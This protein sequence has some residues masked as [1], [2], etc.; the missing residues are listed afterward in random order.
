VPER[1]EVLVTR[2]EIVQVLDGRTLGVRLLGGE[3]VNL[4]LATPDELMRMNREARAELVAAL[5]YEVGQ[6]LTREQAEQMVEPLDLWGL[7]DQVH[8]RVMHH[9]T[10]EERP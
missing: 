9:R 7:L 10:S 3:E 6:G 8:E 1:R 4:R 5:G 2:P